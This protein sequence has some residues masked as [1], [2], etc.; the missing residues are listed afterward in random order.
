VLVAPK[1]AVDCSISL[2]IICQS[3]WGD[4]LNQASKLLPE[5]KL[6]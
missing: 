1:A 5:G 3:T 2:E 4:N 6:D